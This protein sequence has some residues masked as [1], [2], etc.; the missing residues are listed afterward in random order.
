MKKLTFLLI[1]LLALTLTA[2]NAASDSTEVA[3]SSQTDPSAQTLSGPTLLVL[4][5]LKLDGTDQAVTPEQA[6]ELLPL[7]QVYGELTTS[8]TAAQAET[9][10]LLQQIEDA[11]TVEQMKAINEM[12]LTPQDMMTA[13]DELGLGM[14]RQAQSDSDDSQGG[15]F[16]PPDGG[17]PP[18][19]AGGGPGGDLGGQGLSPEQIATAQA[20][21]AERTASGSFLPPGLL[22]ALIEYLQ[23][24]AGS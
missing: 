24:I 8:D 9:D 10:A 20:A 2:C 15:G 11:L 12:G 4:G 13:M 3:A 18:G 1:T 5:I 16:A 6:A 21:R 19:M 22:D 17:I 23:E 14:G 7:W